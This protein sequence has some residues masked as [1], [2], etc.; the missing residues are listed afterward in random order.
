MTIVG[1]QA[2]VAEDIQKYGSEGIKST[3]LPRFA[4]G[5]VQGAMDL[6]EPQAG[7]DLGAITTRAI[8][9]N[10]RF[11]LEGQK[12]FITNGGSEVHLV[13]ARDD[14]TFDESRGTTN[15]LSLFLCP[16]TLP[17]GAKNPI[18]VERLEEKLGIH[19]SPTCA[20]RFSRAEGFRVGKKGE[21]FRAMLDLMNNARLGVA[22]QGIGIAEAALSE[23]IRYA[24]ERKQFGSPIAQQPLMK[25]ML[26]R[27]V[28]ALEGSRALLYR[29][30]TLVDRNRAIEAQLA[31]DGDLAE[32]ERV[33]LEKTHERNQVRIRLLTPLAKYL[34]TEACDR[35]SREAIQVH[36]GL[37]FMAETNVAKLHQDAIIT[38]IYEGTSE[39]QVSFA[40]KEMGKGALLVVFEEVRRE[41]DE[42]TEEPLDAY[43]SKVRGGIEKILQ[44]SAAL[45][46]DFNYALLS[47]KLIAES[48]IYVI[49][50]AELLKQARLA[51][52]RLDLAAS[53]INQR[54]LEVEMNARRIAEGDVT[55]LERCERILEL[56]S[57]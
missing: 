47:S 14:D 11:F 49:V 48:V 34:A 27:M 4:S 24:N 15:G 5:E 22:A 21:G 2:G 45:I 44:A 19:G 52:E 38:T 12:I 43:A 54:M 28:V 57:I 26:S 39:I 51:P 40:L 36:G 1:L 46:T 56:A 23:A 25:N 37:G 16:R 33:E 17:D 8:E 53:W 7:S 55:R 32:G 6:T 41:L 10:G 18:E 13:L 9:E 35:I 29:C 50:G 31:R 3:Y 20:V 42:M 30:C